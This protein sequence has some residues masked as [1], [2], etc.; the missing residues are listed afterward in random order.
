MAIICT[1]SKKERVSSTI[2]IIT[3]LIIAVLTALFSV[4]AYV[5]LNHNVLND[6]KVILWSSIIG[7]GLLIISLITLSLWLAQNLKRLEKMK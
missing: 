1:I 5:V 4:L 7:I 3:A 6:D 2:N